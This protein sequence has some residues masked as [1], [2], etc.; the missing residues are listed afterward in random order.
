MNLPPLTAEAV[1]QRLDEA[2]LTLWRLEA[3]DP[4]LGQPDENTVRRMSEARGWLLLIP[5]SR[6]ARIVEARMMISPRTGRPL[7]SWRKL[8][9]VIGIDHKTVKVWYNQGVEAIVKG[10][11]AV[12]RTAH[13]SPTESLVDIGA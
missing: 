11:G 6:D 7:Y 1:T 9:A 10:L 4:T 2:G 8:G 12:D 5:S 13:G 3:A